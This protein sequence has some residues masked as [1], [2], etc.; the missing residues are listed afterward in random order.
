[1]GEIVRILKFDPEH[2]EGIMRVW[3]SI[4]LED[5]CDMDWTNFS[6]TLSDS[7]SFDF[8]GAR[9]ALADENIVGF[10]LGI[11]SKD[12]KE[13]TGYL[14][15]LF[16]APDHQGKGIG[17][18]LLDSIETFL[19]KED[20][21]KLRI[22]YAGNPLSFAAGVSLA[23][24]AYHFFLNRGFRN[25]SYQPA[26]RMRLELKNFRLDK[27]M[28]RFITE[29]EEMGV[30]FGLC[31][32]DYRQA[33]LEFMNTTFPGGWTESVKATL[34]GEAP[35]PV[36]VATCGEKVIGFTGPI[37]VSEEGRGGFTGIGTHP[38]Y[39]RRK[40][41]KILFNLLCQE[42]KKRGADYIPLFT[43][44]DNPA[45]EIYF[46]AGFKVKSLFDYNLIKHL[47]ERS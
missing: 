2:V 34:E 16:V 40:I 1:M 45:Q 7:E 39:R 38:E 24:P 32:K 6:D 26:I 12:A 3:E 42:F 46:S 25:Y 23:S 11:T 17:T 9:V 29:N 8:Q 30:K 21:E 10:G 35:Y 19:K 4:S 5:D 44:L 22:G 33:L 36:V 43:G 41:G 31:E 14:S 18:K 27:N 15:I 28:R 13:K 47:S 37:S 20:V